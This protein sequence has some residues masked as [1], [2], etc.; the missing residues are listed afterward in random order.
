[1]IEKARNGLVTLIV[2]ALLAK[3]LSAI[4]NIVLFIAVPLLVLMLM[5][6]QFYYRRRRW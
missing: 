5:T 2:F 4:I 1:M 3:F 6:E